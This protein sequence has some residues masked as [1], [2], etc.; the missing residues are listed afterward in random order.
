MIIDNNMLVSLAVT[1]IIILGSC[2]MVGG[3][4]LFCLWYDKYQDKQIAREHL[5]N[6]NN[7]G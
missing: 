7:E 6:K 2:A 3:A 5:R 1:G 4:F